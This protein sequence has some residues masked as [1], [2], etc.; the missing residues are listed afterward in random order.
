M[1]IDFV[2]NKRLKSSIE[3]EASIQIDQI[4]YEHPVAKILWNLIL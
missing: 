4:F 3:R 2:F 1:I